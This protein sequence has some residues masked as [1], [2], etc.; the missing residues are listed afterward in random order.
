MFLMGRPGGGYARILELKTLWVL[1]CPGV[2]LEGGQGGAS[3]KVA[4]DG[5]A[6]VNSMV[7]ILVPLF[8]QKK[9]Q[10]VKPD[11]KTF[12]MQVTARLR[13][14][15]AK[16]GAEELP[17][18]LVRLAGMSVYS[19]LLYAAFSDHYAEE[20][21]RAWD[22]VSQ[23]VWPLIWRRTNGDADQ[24]ADLVQQTVLRVAERLDKV[25]APDTFISFIYWQ[26]RAV[27]TDYDRD[28]R[29][30]VPSAGDE[31]GSADD[32]GLPEPRE[33][34]PDD[35]QTRFEREEL[36]RQIREAVERCLE[37]EEQ[38]RAFVG[39][40]F[41]GLQYSELSRALGY[42]VAKCYKLISQAR[43]WLRSDCPRLHRLL[44]QYQGLGA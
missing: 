12:V 34:M 10:L 35:I 20:F 25:K 2:W 43:K 30:N 37:S 4:S 23:T 5:M 38:R 44:R 3:Q 18:R 7:L 11:D 17:E 14:W 16:A 26:A 15:Q 22:E 41:G 19:E 32:D 1:Q 39:H 6:S 29:R 42:T 8:N 27:L 36:R 31:G 21:G 40:F 24:T 13:A 33:P 28:K 9:W